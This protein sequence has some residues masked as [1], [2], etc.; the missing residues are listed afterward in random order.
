MEL[1]DLEKQLQDLKASIEANAEK[2]ANEIVAQQLEAVNATLTELKA[3]QTASPDELKTVKA[4]LDVTIKALDSVMAKM[5]SVNMPQANPVHKTLGG[6][7]VSMVESQ[8]EA[9]ASFEKKGGKLQLPFD[10]KAVVTMTTGAAIESGGVPVTYRQGLVPKPF[11]LVHMRNIFAVTPSATD[12]YDFYRHSSIDGA[13]DY[14]VEGENKEKISDKITEVSV[15]L[16][17]LAGYELISRKMLRNFP[18]LQSYLGRWL[19]E[20]YYLAEDAKGV[21]VLA[22]AAGAGSTVT[23]GTPVERIITAM[24][25]QKN[26]KYNVN[27]I[28]I[29]GKSWSQI[30]LNKASGSGEFDL[31]SGIV[32]VT[33]MGGITIA[34]VPVY[35]AS[36]VQEDQ[37]YIG[38]FSMFEIVQSEAL[39]LRFSEEDGDNFKKNLVTA[40]IE[41]SIGFAFLDPA[42]IARVDLGQFAS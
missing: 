26:A 17:D 33:P 18:A 8:K 29:N 34:G 5:K 36:W 10:T 24:G 9:I 13:P 39:T 11:E 19:P 3:K 22:A 1:K 42:A 20:R 31:P 7:I 23:S 16:K 4:D 41:A 28:L 32:A 2:K 37:A 25:L 12:T 14:Q 15:L 27:G 40:R 21:V 38:D 35:T 30:I 6:N